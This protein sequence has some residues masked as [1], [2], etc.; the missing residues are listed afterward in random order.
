[1]Q[2]RTVLYGRTAHVLPLLVE[3]SQ[4]MNS[5][6]VIAPYKRQGMWVFDDPAVGL[7]KEPFAAGSPGSEI[8]PAQNRI[9]Q[10]RAP[11]QA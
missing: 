11:R 2:M 6:I 1:M 5:L 9:T 7:A 3:W 10:L 4:R 8:R